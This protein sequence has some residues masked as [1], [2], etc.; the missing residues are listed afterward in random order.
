MSILLAILF[1]ALAGAV[2]GTYAFPLKHMKS[3]PSEASWLL[4]S[5]LGFLFFPWI[6]V[7]LLVP[8][9]WSIIQQIPLDTWIILTGSGFVFGLGMVLCTI[10]LRYVGIGI[11]FV[12]NL[13]FGAISG[14]VLP[15]F[16]MA[17]ERVWSVFGLVDFSALLLFLLGVVFA[18][19]AAILRQHHQ[20]THR[21][22]YACNSKFGIVLGVLSGLLTSM[23]GVAYSYA[24]PS[25]QQLSV[26]MNISALGIANIP[27]LGIFTAAFIPFFLYQA[28][29]LQRKKQWQQMIQN[30]K[31]HYLFLLVIMGSF[32]YLS[33]VLYSQACILLG[34]FGSVLAWPMLMI[35]IILAANITG[36]IQGEWVDCGL[37]AKLN[38]FFALFLL[39]AAIFLLSYGAHI[40]ISYHAVIER[41]S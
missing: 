29:M 40:N 16:I 2:N 6:T 17:P 9:L 1:A 41:L 39:A 3:M 15:I 12:L 8:N 10:A 11:A 33:L 22:D 21:G 23:Q 7:H 37:K 25:V 34:D 4:F 30:F 18:A 28:Y 20:G 26:K 35:F 27:W 14:G 5:L 24:L 31:F 38:L 19:K 36:F 32:Y 13:S